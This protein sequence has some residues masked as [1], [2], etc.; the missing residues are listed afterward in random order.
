VVIE[1]VVACGGDGATVARVV[2]EGGVIGGRGAGGVVMRGEWDG[3]DG[4]SAE[5][6]GAAV[7]GR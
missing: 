6:E 2:V 7:M 4:D 3:I 1:S 5:G